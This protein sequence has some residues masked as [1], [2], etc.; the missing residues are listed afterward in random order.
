M[1]NTVMQADPGIAGLMNMANDFI[2]DIGKDKKSKKKKKKQPNL[3]PEEAWDRRKS[4]FFCSIICVC[5]PVAV[6]SMVSMAYLSVMIYIP[7][8]KVFR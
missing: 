6:L 8:R 5:T 3:S 4:N 2:M 1:N 7:V